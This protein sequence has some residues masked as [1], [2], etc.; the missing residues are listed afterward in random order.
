MQGERE[1]ERGRC[2]EKGREIKG[3]GREKRYRRQ[4]RREGEALRE[5]RKL[6]KGERIESCGGREGREK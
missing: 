3:G 5:I 6:E 1:R 2:V 4:E